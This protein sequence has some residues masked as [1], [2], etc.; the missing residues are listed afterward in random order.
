MENSL[1]DLQIAFLYYEWMNVFHPNKMIFNP[2]INEITDTYV[3]FGM[4]KH[5]AIIRA[6][7]EIIELQ[8]KDHL[9]KRELV[10][11]I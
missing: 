3:V 11:F 8:L 7:I 6:S 1:K 9:E 4:A 5:F 2:T 10:P